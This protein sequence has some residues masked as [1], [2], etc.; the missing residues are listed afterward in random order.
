MGA[1]G[2]SSDY[3][4]SQDGMVTNL[5]QKNAIWRSAELQ[6]LFEELWEL[7]TTPARALDLRPKEAQSVSSHL[8]PFGLPP[9]CYSNSYLQELDG[10]ARSCLLT[11]N[12][13]SSLQ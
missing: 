8:V 4:S 1:D 5:R 13:I 7:H 6:K 11:T 12:Q 3:S 10:P 9:T 2:M